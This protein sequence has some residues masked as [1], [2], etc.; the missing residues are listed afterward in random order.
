VVWWVTLISAEFGS[1]IGSTHIV[2][3]GISG[4]VVGELIEVA[5]SGT[6]ATLR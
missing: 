3:G 4:W 5:T 1:M 6:V 2:V